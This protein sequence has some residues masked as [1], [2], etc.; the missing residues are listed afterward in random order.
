MESVCISIAVEMGA[1]K[2]LAAATKP[3]SAGQIAEACNTETLLTERV[4]RC[5]GSYGAVDETPTGDETRYSANKISRVFDTTE[6]TSHVGFVHGILHPGWIRLAR[7]L[8]GNNYRCLTSQIN[9]VLGD[10]R[11]QYDC[12]LWG[13]LTPREIDVAGAFFPCFNPD[14]RDW[15]EVYPAEERLIK[16]AKSDG[17]R[18]LFVD[19]GGGIGVQAAAFRRKFSDAPGKVILQD[20]ERNVRNA[21]EGVEPMGHDFFTPQPIKGARA[22]YLRYI[23][24]CR[25][26]V[27]M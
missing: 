11:G 4:M 22:Y 24:H 18:A 16:G 1:M 19:V 27:N 5:L 13:I 17:D 12:D 3:Q 25:L 21:E 9:C 6:G 2:H 7:K 15:L 10:A 26:L 14:R 23:I 20:F 8:K